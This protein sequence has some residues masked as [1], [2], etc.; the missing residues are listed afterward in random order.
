MTTLWVCIAVTALVSFTLK[1]VGPVALG[2]RPLPVA[3]RD[4]V[5]LLAP[6]MLCALLVTALA[7]PGWRGLDLGVLAGVV[8]AGVARVLRLPPLVCVA[9]G[10]VVTILV[11]AAS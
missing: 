6:V 3:A 9:C 2:D 5:T 8:V 10:I 1:A 4:V 7:G 11:R